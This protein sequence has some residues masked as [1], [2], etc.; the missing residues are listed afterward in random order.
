MIR[1]F[2]FFSLCVLFLTGCSSKQNIEEVSFSSWGSVTEVQ[3][4][5]NVIKEFELENPSIK[6]NFMHIPQ[7]YFQ[8][9]HLLFASNTPPD[10]LFMNNLYLPVYDSKLEDLSDLVEDKEFYSQA[11]SGM[12]YD[13]VLKGVPRDISNLVLY[14][15]ID[16]VNLP[17][18]NWALEDLL[19]I[20][21][22]ATDEN[23][24]GISYENNIYWATPYLSYFGGGVLDDD[25]NLI[26]NSEN[27]QK[28]L[29]FYKD[30]VSKYKV[31]PSESQV[32]SSTL[33][34]MFLD[35]KIAMYMSGRW[36]YPKISEKANFN[37]AVINFPYGNA[38][39]LCDVSGW[40]I[41]KESKHKES[42]KKFVRYLSSEKVSQYFAQT[43][44]VVPARI[45]SAQSLNNG[46]HNEHVFLEI[47]KKTKNTPVCKDYKKIV[48]EIDSKF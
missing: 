2:L 23:T 25:L 20:A 48:D 22:K 10:V 17:N 32:G 7:N 47:I 33:A 19:K 46:N 14:I 36:M 12:S 8:K 42:A 30:L 44:L 3:I 15:N 41:A 31:A 13:G 16:K 1:R 29:N 18:K 6:I 5:K 37:W 34:Q 27:S 24:F 9:I 28:G 26:I 38:S 40:V 43:G 45:S 4:I 11:I 21:K 39:Q 35:E